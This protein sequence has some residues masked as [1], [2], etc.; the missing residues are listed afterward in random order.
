MRDKVIDFIFKTSKDSGISELVIS[1]WLGLYPSKYYSWQNRY[2]KINTHNGRIPRDFWLLDWERQGILDF[3]ALHPLEGYRRLAFMLLDE[4]NVCVSPLSVYRVLVDA[5]LML[6]SNNKTSKKGTGFV[7][8]TRPHEHWHV[9]VS[10]LNIAGTFYYVTLAIDG[11]S[12]TIVGVDALPK[13]ENSDIQMI[14]Q[15]AREKYGGVCPRIISDNGPQFLAMDFKYYIRMSGMTHVRTSP[16]YP[17]SNGKVEAANKTYKREIIR[18]LNP[19][20]VG[21]AK[22]KLIEWVNYYND[23]RL[24][25]SIGYV[26][27]TTMLEGREFE[28]LKQ[29]DERLEA[30][31]AD[32]RQTARGSQIINEIQKEA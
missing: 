15:E 10:Y 2:G 6:K 17:Q 3:H 30:A 18:P 8:L 22:A 28:V 23:H 11:Y 14:I 24:H 20:S 12:R 32:R 19:R 16:F 13:M 4:G 27:P 21:E 1:G 25:S 26:S 7:Q 5:G 9:D 31:R 29:R